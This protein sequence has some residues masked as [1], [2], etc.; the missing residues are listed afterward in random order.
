[1]RPW[2]GLGR[3]YLTVVQEGR[4]LNVALVRRFLV[5]VAVAFWQGGF[6]F[7]SGVV[8]H[9][10]SAVLGS[11]LEQGL[12]TRSVTNYLN[13]A[14]IVALAIWGWDIA[15]ARDPA[16]WRRWLRWSLWT[17][18]LLA[19]GMLAW[20]HAR[21]DLLIDH[22]SSSIVDRSQFRGL[23]VWYLNISTVQWVA[24]L[25]LLM[26]TLTAW[27]A[28]DGAQGGGRPEVEGQ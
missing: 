14:G 13:L 18:L 10:G 2:R 5:L 28:E 24:S 20:W 3:G 4:F 19:L 16:I 11:H 6:T 1:M 21:L 22:E 23:H 15:R 7:Y 9:V 8:V 26:V 17:L 12:V 25:L 27:R